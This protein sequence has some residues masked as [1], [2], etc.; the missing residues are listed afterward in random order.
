M[1]ARWHFPAFF[2]FS[3]DFF[4]PFLTTLDV[5][6]RLS[7]FLFCLLCSTKFV[8]AVQNAITFSRGGGCKSH[9]KESIAAVK[10]WVW[11]DSC[12]ITR[13]K[14]QHNY[15]EL[16]PKFTGSLAI[17]SLVVCTGLFSS[18][19]DTLTLAFITIGHEFKLVA[20]FAKNATFTILSLS[21]E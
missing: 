6:K 3:V 15:L 13:E 5:L 8:S 18:I 11:Q 19:C 14:F 16:F 1:D 4:L 12:S 20:F 7:L 21:L 10:N 17:C 2:K 9:S